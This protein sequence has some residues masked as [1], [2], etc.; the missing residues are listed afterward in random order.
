M[1]K[2]G[3]YFQ[4]VFLYIFSGYEGS[5]TVSDY[6]NAAVK[7]CGDENSSFACLDM[8]FL[9]GLLNSGYGLPESKLINLYKKINGHEA[10][11]ALGVGYHMINN[12]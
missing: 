10:S 8:T 11:W 1:K 2:V 6:K 9:Y 7:A 4:C 5:V 3:F 12:H